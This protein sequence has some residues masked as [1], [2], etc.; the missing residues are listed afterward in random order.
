LFS[1]SEKRSIHTP[2]PQRR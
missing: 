1:C 2:K